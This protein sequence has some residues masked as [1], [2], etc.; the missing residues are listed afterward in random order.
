MFTPSAAASEHKMSELSVARRPRKTI[1]TIAVSAVNKAETRKLYKKRQA[2]YPKLVHGRFRT[3]KWLLLIANLA[4]YYLTPWLRWGRGPGAP[5]QAVLVDFASGR[6]YFFFLEVWPDEIYY[7]TGLLIL[8]ALGLFLFTALLGGVWCG[9]LCP[10]T[11]WTDL[12]LAVERLIECDRNARLRFAAA[13]WSAGKL[14][15]KAS[16]HTIWLLIV[17]ATGGAWVFYFYDAPALFA[18]LFAG[19]CQRR[20]DLAAASRSESASRTQA[21]G[22]PISGAFLLVAVYS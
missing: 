13:P 4:I 19:T 7:I 9:Y 18:Q 8:S 11:I 12:Y 17:A 1:E 21:R 16:K 10:Q 15:Q 5:D 6:F 3:V 2:I 20:R 14:I 22:P